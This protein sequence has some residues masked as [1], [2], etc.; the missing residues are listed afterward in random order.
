MFKTTEAQSPWCNL[1]QADRIFDT[2]DISSLEVIK[3]RNVN[4]LTDPSELL[5]Y[6]LSISYPSH[7]HAITLQYP[8]LKALNMALGQM[9]MYWTE[10]EVDE[11]SLPHQGVNQE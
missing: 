8:T 6:N 2:R 1:G 9:G 3:V 4:S 11:S 10:A 7:S 5:N